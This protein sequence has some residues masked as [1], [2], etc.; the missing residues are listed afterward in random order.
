MLLW[1]NRHV[2]L[3]FPVKEVI[4]KKPSCNASLIVLAHYAGAHIYLCVCVCAH[5]YVYTYTYVCKYTY[6]YMYGAYTYILKTK[7]LIWTLIICFLHYHLEFSLLL[8]KTGT[9]HGIYHDPHGIA[10][11]LE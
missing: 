3:L 7:G 4:D 1:N 9:Y 10:K 2:K 8:R 5:I 6:K 11:F